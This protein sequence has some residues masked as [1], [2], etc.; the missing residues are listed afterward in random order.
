MEAG[1]DNFGINELFH[2]FNYITQT[3]I[4]YYF[5]LGTSSFSLHFHIFLLMKLKTGSLITTYIF[6]YEI[7]G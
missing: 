3:L 4:G 1:R 2:S 6:V 7:M 5:F